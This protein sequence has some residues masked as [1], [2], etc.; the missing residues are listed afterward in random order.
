V[1]RDRSPAWCIEEQAMLRIIEKRVDSCDAC[2]EESSPKKGCEVAY[3][4]GLLRGFVCQEHLTELEQQEVEADQEEAE[5]PEITSPQQ[6]QEM[7]EEE[8]SILSTTTDE[9]LNPESAPDYLGDSP[10][11][12]KVLKYMGAAETS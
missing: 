2:P 12:R 4:G 3:F 10:V 5:L 9:L 6:A 11:L 7:L 8:A 1:A